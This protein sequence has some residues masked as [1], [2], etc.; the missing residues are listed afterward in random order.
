MRQ[1]LDIP[2]PQIMCSVVSP[3]I[4]LGTLPA[5][6]GVELGS[7]SAGALLSELE[8]GPYSGPGDHR[9]GGR[10]SQLQ[11]ADQASGG[12]SL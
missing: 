11:E 9:N 4:L 3:P 10:S 1:G 12:H 8:A 7:A 6:H 5:R 2:L